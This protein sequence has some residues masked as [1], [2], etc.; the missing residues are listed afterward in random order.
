MSD[1]GRQEDARFPW[2]EY[3]YCPACVIVKIFDLMPKT[4]VLA[5]ELWFGDTV[6]LTEVVP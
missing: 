6:K 1:W 5:S 4:A 3:S 2:E